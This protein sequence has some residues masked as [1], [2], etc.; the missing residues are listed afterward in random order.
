[1]G[2][3]SE[4]SVKLCT[5]L[6]PQESLV[7]CIF[8]MQCT[9]SMGIVEDVIFQIPYS[10]SPIN[11]FHNETLPNRPIFIRKLCLIGIFPPFLILLV[12]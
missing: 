1:M 8:D 2:I 12:A 10:D 11:H 9:E 3:K 7:L 4:A 5:Q 6:G